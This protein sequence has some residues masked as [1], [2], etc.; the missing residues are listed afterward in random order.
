M[1]GLHSLKRAANMLAMNGREERDPNR[2][3]NEQIKKLLII[4]RYNN[5]HSENL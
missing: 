5:K 2:I 4:E 3:G 1:G